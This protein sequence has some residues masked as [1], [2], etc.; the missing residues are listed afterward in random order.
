MSEQEKPVNTFY[1]ELQNLV[2]SYAGKL[3]LPEVTGVM[4]NFSVDFIVRQSQTRL[5]ND[6]AAME[7]FVKSFLE[8]DGG[9]RMLKIA[10]EAVEEAE[11]NKACGTCMGGG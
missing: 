5:M 7:S 6:G 10:G 11:N 2:N 9:K 3:N 8:S 1:V 4:F